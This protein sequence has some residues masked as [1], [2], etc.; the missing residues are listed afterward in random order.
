MEIFYSF[1]HCSSGVNLKQT[2]NLCGIDLNY[3]RRLKESGRVKDFET[4]RKAKIKKDL[5]LLK[6]PFETEIQLEE[7]SFSSEISSIKSP[8]KVLIYLSHSSYVIDAKIIEKLI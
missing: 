7:Q 6:N 3:D 1:R 2:P 4:F 5:G 8:I